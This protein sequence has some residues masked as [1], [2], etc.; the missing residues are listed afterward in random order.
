MIGGGIIPSAA[1]CD[2]L[3]GFITCDEVFLCTAEVV[4]VVGGGMLALDIDEP[5]VTRDVI[6]GTLVDDPDELTDVVRRPEVAAGLTDM[7]LT[8]VTGG[9]AGCC[10]TSP[11]LSARVFL[12]GFSGT[13]A[14][15]CQPGSPDS[16][17]TLTYPQTALRLAN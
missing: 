6:E 12:F 9:A 13:L 3:T 7:L 10:P 14:P 15:V 1:V 4:L 2:A 5:E 17:H 11:A 8:R 16:F